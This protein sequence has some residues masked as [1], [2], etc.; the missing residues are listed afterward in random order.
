MESEPGCCGL[1]NPM[2]CSFKCWQFVVSVVI[3]FA[4]FAVGVVG[5]CGLFAVED[6]NFYTY[7]IVF[8]LGIWVP[9]PN[10][11]KDNNNV[12]NNSQNNLK[13]SELTEGVTVAL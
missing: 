10:M 3:S 11:S 7:L 5:L 13:K 8:V 2:Y 9:T 12:A 6:K 4:A 1:L